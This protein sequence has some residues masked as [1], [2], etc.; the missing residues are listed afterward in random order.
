ML[1]ELSWCANPDILSVMVSSMRIQPQE[2]SIRWNLMRDNRDLEVYETLPL[3]VNSPLQYPL[4]SQ[5]QVVVGWEPLGSYEKD[6]RYREETKTCMLHLLAARNLILRIVAAAGEADSLPLLNQLATELKK[7]E[8]EQIPEI[9]N[10]LESRGSGAR[11]VAVPL[12]AVERLREARESEQ[13]KIIAGL[14]ECLSHSPSPD[15][16]CLKDLDSTLSLQT[17]PI[18]DRE[19]P[20]SYKNFLLRA[21]TCGETLALLGAICCGFASSQSP[22]S[23]KNNK[24]SGKKVKSRMPDQLAVSIFCP[25]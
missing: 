13:L 22:P 9:L 21:N 20:A 12:D 11:N 3:I 8:E 18:P 7:L 23:N 17:L 14:A 2:D 4:Y 1:L 15:S 25:T 24:K 10:L 19:T 16:Q 6:P 5:N